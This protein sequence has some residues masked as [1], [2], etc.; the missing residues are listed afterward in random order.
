MVFYEQTE[1]TDGSGS[2]YSQHVKNEDLT[3]LSF[4]ENLNDLTSFTIM[5]T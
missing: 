1:Q 3:L 4:L 2:H 5:T